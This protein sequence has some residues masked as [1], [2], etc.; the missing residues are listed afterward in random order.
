MVAD[1]GGEFEAVE[2]GHAHV[3]ENDGDLRLEQ[4]FQCGFGGRRLDQVLAQFLQHHLIA[5]EL[6]RLI[7]DQ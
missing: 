2:L 6:G 3:D 1:H 4:R 7:V 5:E